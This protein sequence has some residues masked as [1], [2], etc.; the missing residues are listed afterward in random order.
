MDVSAALDDRLLALEERAEADLELAQLG[1]SVQVINHEFGASIQA[2]R[3]NIRRLKGWADLNPD[4]VDVYQGIRSSF[5]HLDG[6]LTLF[7]PLQKRLYRRPISISGADIYK[8]LM[9]VFRERLAKEGVILNASDEFLEHRISGY[10]STFFPAIINLVD[11]AFFWL[12]RAPQPRQILLSVDGDAILVS[13]N[14][15][16][17]SERDQTS[18]FELGFTR[19]PGGRGLGLHIARQALNRDGFSLQLR[20]P[21]DGMNVTFS[22]DRRPEVRDIADDDSAAEEERV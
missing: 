1:L 21:L 22:I 3:E 18:I 20:A 6:Y 13:N 5:D 11:N 17:V 4:L 8:F 15:P 10:P 16:E 14:G 2:V 12:D 7:T 19:K 9:D